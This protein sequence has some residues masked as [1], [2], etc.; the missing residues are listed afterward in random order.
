MQNSCRQYLWFERNQLRGTLVNSPNEP[1]PR[2]WI[3]V[4]SEGGFGQSKQYIHL[5][6]HF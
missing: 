5:T 2:R 1:V 6:S 4:T 3:E